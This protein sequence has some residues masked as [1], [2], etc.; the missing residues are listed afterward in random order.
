MTTQIIGRIYKITSSEC[1]GVYIGSTT[2]PLSIRLSKHKHD[3]KRYLD[4]RT[5]SFYM[6]SYDIIKYS[7][8]KIELIIEG[9]FDDRK[10]LCNI[11]GEI[12]RTTSCCVNKIIPNRTTKE[13]SDSI[14]EYNAIR[15]KNKSSKFKARDQLTND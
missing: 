3:Y 14:K 8:V 15:Y 5:N 1:E 2:Q 12:I 11:E 7:D 4:G 9:I 13:I 6:T 10:D